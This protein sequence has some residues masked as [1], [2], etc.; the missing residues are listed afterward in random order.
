MKRSG[1][2]PPTGAAAFTLIELLVVIAIIALLM[3]FLL[4]NLSRAKELARQTI[5]RNNLSS[6]GKGWEGYFSTFG[7]R[8]PNMFN[9]LPGTSDCISQFNYLIWCGRGGTTH[10]HPDY[11]N[12]GM[13]YKHK[14]I[15]SEETYLCPTMLRN[16]GYH[17]FDP[18][19]GSFFGTYPNPWPVQNYPHTRMTYGTRRMKAYDD[20]TLAVEQNHR[21]PRDDH[22]MIWSAGIATISRTSEF[23]F[24]A[25]NFQM[26]RIALMS[27]VPGV[28]VLYLDGHVGY[29]RDESG[30]ILYDNGITGWGAEFNWL[31]DKIWMDIDA[32]D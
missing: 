3:S 18:E 9:P 1:P 4:P 26:P 31:H 15:S 19:H 13:L 27:H 6:L 11:V 16:Q 12:A 14:F 32:N 17:W 24:M 25:D 20:P 8:T 30:K 23:S 29:F 10:T 21:D 7:P 28:N 2:K 22:I 5:C